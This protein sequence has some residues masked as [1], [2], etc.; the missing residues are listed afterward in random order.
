MMEK[1]K[2]KLSKKHAE[3][4]ISAAMGLLTAMLTERGWDEED[5]IGL[6]HQII[7]EGLGLTQEVE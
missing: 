2:K 3:I 4:L 7:A 6:K 1:T 5:I